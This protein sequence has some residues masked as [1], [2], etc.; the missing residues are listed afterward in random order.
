MNGVSWCG[1]FFFCPTN[2]IIVFQKSVW[3]HFYCYWRQRNKTLHLC[4]YSTKTENVLLSNCWGHCVV[5]FMLLLSMSLAVVSDNDLSFYCHFYQ[6]VPS[7]GSS[8]KM[9]SGCFL[10]E[11]EW[12]REE[13]DGPA[14]VTAAWLFQARDEEIQPNTHRGLKN[15]RKHPPTWCLFFSLS[16]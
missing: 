1:I 10:G 3:N 12:E 4:L 6:G 5:L 14:S 15:W 11:R 8:I 9:F 13:G 16:Q 2:C 7:E